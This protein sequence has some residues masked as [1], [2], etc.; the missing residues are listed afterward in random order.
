MPRTTVASISTAPARPMPS[1]C[2]R[3]TDTVSRIEN[4]ATMITAALVTTPALV[5]MPPITACL[6]E[7]PPARS[8]AIRLRMNT[9]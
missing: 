3:K 2:S 1:D 6:V 8:S 9:W 4:T 7:A 5:E